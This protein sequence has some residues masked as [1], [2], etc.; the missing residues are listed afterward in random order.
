M[1]L[2]GITAALTKGR[3]KSAPVSDRDAVPNEPPVTSSHARATTELEDYLFAHVFA[4][5]ANMVVE[6]RGD[7]PYD[8]S[9]ELDGGP[10]LV[11]GAGPDLMYDESGASFVRVNESRLYG[12][13]ELEAFGEHRLI[14]RSDSDQFAVNSFTF[15]NYVQGP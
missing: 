2:R 7:T 1:K 14:V 4:R 3:Q 5:S 12:L 11:A 10:V 9:V 8:V 6:F 13:L 15:G